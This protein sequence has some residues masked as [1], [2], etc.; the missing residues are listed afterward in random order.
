MLQGFSRTCAL[1]A[2]AVAVLLSAGGTAAA[3]VRIRG[4][5]YSGEP[6]G[7]GCVEVELPASMAPEPLGW[8]GLGIAERRHR[9]LYPAVDSQSLAGVVKEVLGQVRSPAA[10]LLGGVIEGR[11]KARVYFLFLGREPLDL[12]VQSQAP[13][14]TS[15]T[16]VE[17]QAGHRRLLAAWWKHYTARPGLLQA[18][19]DYPPLVENY[20]RAMLARRLG[21]ELAERRKGPSW[22]DELAQ[23]LS[24]LAGTESLRLSVERE[25]FLAGPA[26]K[27]TADQPL[28]Q[29]VENPEPAVPE[30]AADVAVEP[31]ASRVPAEW[32]YVRFGSFANFLWFQDTLERIGGDFQNLVA[33]RGLD[34]GTRER[35]ENQLASQ[36]T[37][38][39]R[40][41]GDTIVADVAIVGTDL[42][43]QEGGAY[44]LLFQARSNTL[45]GTS[46]AQ[47]RQEWK[48]KIP[49]TTETK[50]K[51]GDRDVSFLASPDG[52]VRSYYVIDGDYHFIT[53]SRTLVGRFLE[54]RSGKGSLGASREFR[55]ARTLMPLARNDTVF[56]YLSSAF[57]QNLLSPA[58]RVEMM[59]RVEAVADIELA[60]MASLASATEGKPGETIDE[61]V[62]GGFLP[63]GFGVRP[64]GSR[65]VLDKGDARDSL[66]GERGLMTPIPDMEV[67]RVTPPEAAAY[68]QLADLARTRWGRLDPILAG[69]RRQSLQQDRDRV[70]VDLRMTPLDKS[71]VELLGRFVGPADPKRVTP[72]AEDSLALEV[73][74]PQQR[75]FGGL[76]QVGP[77]MEIVDGLALPLGRLRNLLTGYLGTSDEAGL[78][79]WIPFRPAGP[80]D[81]E[82]YVR[83]DLGLWQR[84]TD[85]FTVLSF[86]RD[87]LERV[88]SQLRL[89]DA[90]RPAQLRL[91]VS[92][93]TK[94]PLASLANGWGY[95]R[96][97]ETSLGNVRLMH[98]IAQ[99]LHIPG[100]AAKTAAEVLLD[101][102]LVC[103]LGGQYVYRQTPEG[104]GFWTSTALEGAP[105]GSLLRPQSPEGYQA[106][107]LNWFRGLKLDATL[108]DS[109]VAAHAELDMQWPAAPK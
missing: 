15:V 86:H 103:P 2:A 17:N 24:L 30:P 6:F 80:P 89:E 91:R 67:A 45:L 18:K 81:A 1:L 9:A 5:A 35:F 107:P 76:Q 79:G 83:G 93:L 8:S 62:A 87:V 78:L 100:D 44:G 72:M 47:Q 88:T 104:I 92:D 105:R 64:D 101:A 97:R 98:Q 42:F 31:L 77:G 16:P 71:H 11:G 96:T 95:S 28:P 43:L 109:A 70:T 19:P 37:A 74:L 68:Q 50:L 60:E 29:A 49:G 39:A 90:E 12:T 73:M 55:H 94:S 3:L 13:H 34:R 23:E 69:I 63:P 27:A 108:T 4:E 53:T 48:Q 40:L 102:K 106:P 99:Q 56:A 21:L 85:Q 36:T 65:T 52:R 20:F 54:T 58:Y 7:V 51:I 14:A 59:R 41:L 26:A 32:V 25:R 61:L 33:S 57:F 10:R 38:M 22:Q 46:F 66:R 84:K 82:G 75:I